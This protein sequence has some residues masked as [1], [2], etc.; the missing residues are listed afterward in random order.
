MQIQRN[1]SK[2]MLESPSALGEPWNTNL[3]FELYTSHIIHYQKLSKVAYKFLFEHQL[4][5]WAT[6]TRWDPPSYKTWHPQIG[7]VRCVSFSEV[8]C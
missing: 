6:P 7:L 2:N 8:P 4:E 3:D 1:Y 5:I